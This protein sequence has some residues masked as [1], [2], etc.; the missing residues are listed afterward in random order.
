MVVTG[1]T[2]E[3]SVAVVY[4]P[5]VLQ[6]EGVEAGGGPEP[7]TVG[8]G[9]S[10]WRDGRGQPGVLAG[11]AVVVRGPRPAA[12]AGVAPTAG[13]FVALGVT[14]GA[15]AG[16]PGCG[17][18]RLTP[19]HLTDSQGLGGGQAVAQV[20]HDVAG[21]VVLARLLGRAAVGRVP[22]GGAALQLRVLRR[23]D[24]VDVEVRI[25]LVGTARLPGIYPDRVAL[26]VA[27]GRLF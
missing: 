25:V 2:V 4:F 6:P 19:G 3:M 18:H 23:A 22:V 13:E 11:P 27:L 1:R 10:E 7:G 16:V 15:G 8:G 12:L 5:G 26:Q 21:G 24:L 17:L 20:V 14:A 9:T